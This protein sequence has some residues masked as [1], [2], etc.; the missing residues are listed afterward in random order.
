M[1][2]PVA[3]ALAED[4]GPPT[5]A[6]IVVTAPLSRSREDVIAG[7]SVL[8]GTEL[9]QNLK[10]TIA[11][12]LARTPGVSASS[13]GP[14]ASRPI[15]RGFQGDR[16]R[17][18]TDGVGSFDASTASVDHAVVINPLLAER[19]EVVR[20]PSA[21]LYGS[22]AIGG[23]VNVMDTRIPRTIPE[24][25]YRLTAQGT[26]GSASNERSG[27]VAAD[28]K[29]AD[30]LVLHVDGSYL[31][32]GDQRIGGYALTPALRQQALATAAAGGDPTGEIDFAGN[33]AV[34][35][36]LPNTQAKTWEVG[37]GATVI[38]ETGSLGFSYSHYDSLYGVPIRYATQLGEEQEAPRID[39]A[40]DR[41]DARA[42]IDTGGN[43]LEAIRFRLGAA[44][45]RHYE[46]EED[47]SIGTA[48]YNQ[49]ME[50]RLELAQAQ[51]GAWRGVTGAQFVYRDFDV[52]GDEAFLPR[53]Q[54]DQQGVF[55][56]Q[57]LD[58]GSFKIEA[59]GR[60]EHSIAEGKPRPDQPQFL[61]AKE[62][63]DLLS[64]SLGASVAVTDGIKIG[65]NLSHSERAP[66]AEELFANGPHAGTE[67]FEIGEPG[68]AKEK[69]NGAEAVLHIHGH[70]FDIEGSAYY[71]RFAN[72]IDDLPTGTLEDG[73][74]VFQTRQGKARYYGFEAQG[75]L[76]LAH[77]GATTIA[78]DAL[79]DYVNAQILDVGPAPRIPPLRVLGGI[80]ARGGQVF[81]RAEVERAASQD[82]IS[83]FETETKGWTTV[84]ASIGVH[85]F[86]DRKGT[87]II[88]SANN[89]FDV[90]ARRASSFLKDYA[91]LAGRDI[92][93][94]AR[95]QL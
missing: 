29:A 52:V 73:L 78:L 32:T 50:G 21:L 56:L 7:V 58:Y 2:L 75:S 92:R 91:P 47:N 79:A 35:D 63:F 4:A 1:L 38:T 51:H 88:L 68:L 25:G 93:V 90:T 22:E 61:A 41:I 85:P 81:G 16:V 83:D 95:F 62:S 18:L 12:T 82:R 3:A 55:T 37:V 8:S 28:V 80:E 69:A 64:G 74:P 6:D 60:Y 17:V 9:A 11:E 94:T 45:Y 54:T 46:L 53:T 49:G 23:V 67:A 14:S 39:V 13:F 19:I 89:L 42:Q 26:Y 86:A 71:T 10:P 31:K 65:L 15:L 48:F 27:G 87:S 40:Q 5:G 43:L 34:K 76:D 30:N 70:G 24:N 59:G 36:K 84:N 77:I 72:Y 33:A 57:Q 20:G 66:S 44:R